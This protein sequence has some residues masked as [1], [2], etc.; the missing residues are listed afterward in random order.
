MILENCGE[1]RA[2]RRLSPLTPTPPCPLLDWEMRE[3][4]LGS[5]QITYS[6]ILFCSVYSCSSH[7]WV[8]TSGCTLP[9]LL[10]KTKAFGSS[11]ELMYCL[12]PLFLEDCGFMKYLEFLIS[13]R[14]SA[15]FPERPGGLYHIA[16]NIIGEIRTEDTLLR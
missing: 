4:D 12:F 6:S 13:Q 9:S 16:L 3:R 15:D 7:S 1:A 2:I 5:T 10:S 8:P 14:K 11:Q